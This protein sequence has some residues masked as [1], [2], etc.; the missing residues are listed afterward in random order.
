MFS[1]FS[2]SSSNVLKLPNHTL[3][4]GIVIT[5]LGIFVSLGSATR[6]YELREFFP[7]RLPEQVNEFILSY[8]PFILGTFITTIAALAGIIVGMNW[9]TGGLREIFSPR[10]TL[11][12]VGDYYRPEDISL[13]LKEGRIR[14]YERAPTLLFFIIG[15]LW[16]NA[17]Y[18]S[19]IPREIVKRNTRFIWKAAAAGI[20]I[21][22]GFKIFETIPPYLESMGLGTGYVIPSPAPFYN[23]LLIVCV[24]KFAVTLSLIPLKRPDATREMDSMIVEGKG[25]PSVFFSILEEGSRMFANRGF[26]NRISRSNP[27]RCQDGESLV[28][29]LIESFPE[30]IKTY[31]RTAATLSLLLGSVM[32]LVGFLQ[33]VLAQ[34]PSF[35]VGY[36]DFFR[37]HLFSLLADIVL[38]VMVILLG[39]NFVNQ[40]RAI[41]GVY[42]FRS[43][44]VY[45]EAKGDF[46]RKVLP[47]LSGIVAAERLFN[48]LASCAFNV[49]YFSAEAISESITP[50]GVRDLIGLETSTRLAKDVARLKFLPFHVNFKE[51]YPSAW[52]PDTE[53]ELE[54]GEEIVRA[55]EPEISIASENNPNLPF[56]SGACR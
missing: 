55:A 9:L 17:R 27:V 54:E 34:Y 16:R 50:Q 48:P 37:L 36:E 35:S 44:L 39:K 7:I 28:G 56:Q 3:F 13:G 41:M 46:E 31:S 38:N 33:I 5:S 49:R 43:N 30:Y 32:I 22:F 4:Y 19:A 14:S 40:A 2:R 29:T 52:K 53:G 20:L 45:V 23:L 25:H 11:T 8:I 1:L 6:L 10:L 42:R 24:V 26:S 12:Q 21:H 51:R 15:K 47:D 18:I